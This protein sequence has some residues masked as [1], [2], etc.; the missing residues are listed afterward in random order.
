MFRSKKKLAPKAGD[1]GAEPRRNRAPMGMFAVY[2]DEDMD[3]DDGLGGGGND[4]AL[5]AELNQLLGGGGG[6]GGKKKPA[7]KSSKQLMDWG[8]LDAQISASMKDMDDDVDIG[9]EEEGE[10][11]AEL[12]GLVS[13]EEP[14]ESLQAPTPNKRRSPSPLPSPGGGGSQLQIL[15]ERKKNYETAIQNAEAKGESSKVRRYQRGNKTLDDLLKKAKAGKTI[16]EDD[17][18]PPVASG[19]PDASSAPPTKESPAP[20]SPPS[21]NVSEPMETGSPM[22]ATPPLPRPASSPKPV[23]AA[24]QKTDKEQKNVDPNTVSMLVHRQQ[25]FKQA[26]LTAKQSGNKADALKYFKIVK[27]FDSVISAANA[28]EPVDLS[29]MPKLPEDGASGRTP[30]VP[31]RAAENKPKPAAVAA[32]P[33]VPTQQPT[34]TAQPPTKQ[35]VPIPKTIL[36]G[37]I[38]R[39]Q[40]Y[41]STADQAKAEGNG[42][43]SR[44]MMRIVKQYDD[45]IRSHKAGKPVAVNE[46]PV[47]MGYPPLPG[48]KQ[49]DPADVLAQA[50]NLLKIE[51]DDGAPQPQVANAALAATAAPSQPA[52]QLPAPNTLQKPKSPGRSPSPKR[53]SYQSQIE[54]L[55]NRQAEF[56]KAALAAKNKGDKVTAMDMLKKM[57]GFEP[58]IQQAKNGLKVDITKVPQPPIVRTP[59]AQ[60]SD[61]TEFEILGGSGSHEDDDQIYKTLLDTLKE[62]IKKARGYS[63]QFTHSGDVNGANMFDK[64]SRDSQQD[65]DFVKNLQRHSDP[66]PRYYFDNKTFES[67]HII[68]ELNSSEMELVIVQLIDVDGHSKEPLVEWE[69]PFPHDNPI[70]GKTEQQSNLKYDAQFR[71]PINR[72][73]K[74]FQRAIK[75]K[76]V[77]FEVIQKGGFLRSDKSLGSA[78]VKLGP[79]ETSCEIRAVEPLKEGRAVIGRIEVKIRMR[80]PLVG[81]E[82]KTI[83]ERWLVV[84]HEHVQRRAAAPRPSG[85]KPKSAASRTSPKKE[86]KIG[87]LEVLALEKRMVEAKIKDLQGKGE[88][89][90]TSVLQNQ[91]TV[92]TKLNGTQK[93]LREGGMNAKRAYVQFLKSETE[94]LKKEA[95]TYVRQGKHDQAKFSLTKRKMIENELQKMAPSN[96]YI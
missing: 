24:Q 34:E 39:Q 69:M 84:S 52:R 44:R 67:V 5:E 29:Q 94:N 18:P 9:D 21:I 36:E 78:S 28:G 88:R 48:E 77:K 8:D 65:L 14:D 37:L 55:E 40:K 49:S 76:A 13:D 87:S 93:F 15:Q 54:F 35:A 63:E 20:S 4:K 38:Q 80:T 1:G 60:K 22:K 66:P 46:L 51:D 19:K 11:M 42:S 72:K 64:L 56:K 90:P 31:P 41:K 85:S 32:Q 91:Q 86:S 17:I 45:A 27:Q 58:M 75:N 82:T 43:K 89:P 62:Q 47:P 26:A 57:K 7:P 25:Q 12:E 68:P 6:G 96:T 10:F 59:G 2:G 50:G 70:K 71:V 3:L 92:L 53:S 16:N 79:L 61:D 23:Q 83:T 73:N 95:Q 30:P 33:A 74:S 81:S